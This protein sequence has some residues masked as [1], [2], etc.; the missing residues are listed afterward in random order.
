MDNF[1]KC[2]ECGD[3]FQLTTDT[4]VCSACES[5]NV[6]EIEKEGLC[7]CIAGV[8]SVTDGSGFEAEELV[9]IQELGN[10]VVILSGENGE[11][12]LMSED[13]FSDIEEAF[14][15]VEI[16]ATVGVSR[17]L[18]ADNLREELMS[19]AQLQSQTMVEDEGEETLT[20]LKK[21]GKVVCKPGFKRMG[22]KCVRM[23][24]QEKAARKRQGKKLGRF[25]KAKKTQAIKARKKTMKSR[26]AKGYYK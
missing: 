1:Y 21:Y 15:E 25:L 12:K 8:E 26:A 13:D 9:H 7:R 5:E 2:L 11:T 17:L 18:D 19:I 6:A 4:E 23:T 14:E 22:V 3:E 16:P 20:E 24:S 10:G